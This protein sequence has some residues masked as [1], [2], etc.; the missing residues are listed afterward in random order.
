M[1]RIPRKGGT[2]SCRVYGLS[3]LSCRTLSDVIMWQC[4]YL[5][6]WGEYVETERER[7]RGGK[8]NSKIKSHNN[9]NIPLNF[10]VIVSK[11]FFF[12]FYTSPFKIWVSYIKTI[13]NLK[14]YI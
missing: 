13:Y 1:D 3:D 2:F 14:N 4:G 12:S 10:G 5:C 8:L 9:Y 11:F 6:M 7:E